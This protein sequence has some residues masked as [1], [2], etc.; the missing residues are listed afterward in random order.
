MVAFNG[1][2]I[3]FAKTYVKKRKKTQNIDPNQT[4]LLESLD[5]S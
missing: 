4:S 5:N 2:R 1:D 3:T